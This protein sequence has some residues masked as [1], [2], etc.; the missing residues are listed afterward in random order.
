MS[1]AT[2]TYK[3]GQRVLIRSAVFRDEKVGIIR[4]FRWNDDGDPMVRVD[5]EP[6]PG[7]APTGASMGWLFPVTSIVGPASEQS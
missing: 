3:V 5:L 6:P 1:D 4:S 7:R 2:P